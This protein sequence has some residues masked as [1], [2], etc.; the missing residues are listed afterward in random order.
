MFLFLPCFTYP[1][2]HINTIINHHR[3]SWWDNTCTFSPSCSNQNI[4]LLKLCYQIFFIF[5]LFILLPILASLASS[6]LISLLQLL[7]FQC[8]RWT[9]FCPRFLQV[10]KFLSD[11]L[12]CKMIICNHLLSFLHTKNKK[13][14]RNTGVGENFGR[15]VTQERYNAILKALM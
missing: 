3:P 1:S 4:T 13:Q 7:P 12:C 14:E 10:V 15:N 11:I 8:K 6:Y 9:K 2:E 5:I